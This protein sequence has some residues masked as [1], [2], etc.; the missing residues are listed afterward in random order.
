MERTKALVSIAHLR[1]FNGIE[2]DTDSYALGYQV[3]WRPGGSWCF[4]E[5]VLHWCNSSVTELDA[6]KQMECARTHTGTHEG[7][8]KIMEQQVSNSALVWVF[9]HMGDQLMWLCELCSYSAVWV[10][11]EWQSGVQDQYSSDCEC[12][13]VE[14]PGVSVTIMLFHNKLFSFQW[15]KITHGAQIILS[16]LQKKNAFLTLICCLVS[17][18]NTYKFK[19]NKIIQCYWFPKQTTLFL[20]N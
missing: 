16:T 6:G 14:E 19:K 8:Q 3:R 15:I 10:I 20:V 17:R 1:V 2:E 11:N 5:L 4:Q 9:V 12:W 18:Q 13:L 7:I